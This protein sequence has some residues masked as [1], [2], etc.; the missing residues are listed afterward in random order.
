MFA[1]EDTGAVETSEE[2]GIGADQFSVG[3][4]F[5][6]LDQDGTGI[7]FNQNHDVM[8]AQEGLMGKL[9]GLVG[10]DSVASV[11]NVGEDVAHFVACE[12]HGM[13]VFKVDGFG[14]CGLNILSGLVEMA[15]GGLD[16]FRVVFLYV[17]DGEEGPANEIASLDSL[18]LGVFN[19]VATHGMHPLDG[20]F[21]GW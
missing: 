6:W 18:D 5:E 11:I 7:D 4:V 21:G 14:L 16:G 1:R 19:W 20:L 12:L 3:A 17:A 10:K 13:K 8:V 9:S 2:S 15:F